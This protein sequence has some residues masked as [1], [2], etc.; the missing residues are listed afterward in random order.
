[1]DREQLLEMKRTIEAEYRADIG[2]VNRLLGRCPAPVENTPPLSAEGMAADKPVFAVVQEAVEAQ[3]GDFTLGK[4]L[5]FVKTSTG[6]E[7]QK[8]TV[9]TALFRL[10]SDGKIKI[11]QAG[12]GRRP[13]IY[14]KA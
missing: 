9:S 5:S 8:Q 14:A 12:Q 1:M 13:A 10:K 11:V 7:P 4:I 3:N 6:N 2:A